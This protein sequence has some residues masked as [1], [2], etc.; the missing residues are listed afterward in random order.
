M[1]HCKAARRVVLMILGGLSGWS[2]CAQ[3]GSPPDLTGVSLE[4]L[5]DL[6]VTSVSKKEQSLSKTAGAVLV[7]TREDIKHSGATNLPD[8]LR[9]VPGVEVARING[10]VWAISIRGFN[11]RYSGTVLV[12][13]D[14]RSVYNPLF[15]GVYWDQESMPLENIERI[16]VIR[17]PSGTVWGANAMNGAINIIT[18]SSASTQGALVSVEAGSH[19]L[20]QE[21]V[22][23]GGSAGADG[24]Y[25]VYGRY[26][27]TANSPQNTGSSAIDRGHNIQMGFRSD[28]TLSPRDTLTV[29]GDALG[30]AES[31]TVSTVSVSA[32]PSQRTFD[33]QVRAATSNLTA[34]WNHTFSDGSEFKGQVYFD[35]VRRFDQ[36]LHIVNTG[37]ADFQYHFREGER[38]DIVAGFGYRL[39]DQKFSDGYGIT[40]G[41]GARRD[42]LFNT[43][44]QDEIEVTRN[45]SLTA[46]VKLEHNAYTGFEYEPSTQFVWSPGRRHTVWG[47]FSK[48]IQQPTWLNTQMQIDYS[49][50][51]IP[52]VGTAVVHISGNPLFR[53]PTVF[54]YSAG[55]RA[56]ISRRFTFDTTLFR[57]YY[58]RLLTVEPGTPYFD[59]SPAFPHLVLPQIYENLGRATTYGVET[60][61]HWNAT[62][63]WRISPGFSVLHMDAQ[64]GPGSAD[65]GFQSAVSDSSP[66]R[67]IQF[68]SNMKLPHNLEWDASAF[69][70]GPVASGLLPAYVRMD[71]TVGWQLTESV[72]LSLTGQNLLSPHHIE[73]VDGY[74]IGSTQLPRAVVARITWRPW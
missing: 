7:I 46:G 70:V 6:Q 15:A 5:M 72:E 66:R 37:D 68:R 55:Y 34:K 22:Q 62:R 26:A 48:A 11:N 42:S 63:W 69:Y 51:Q 52:G 29:Q 45:V 61:A 65:S 18:K 57:S 12:L 35:R 44:L 60:A 30:A 67:Q 32:L 9:M 25:R 43:F 31:Q 27:L 40:V 64:T 28:W 8:L 14:G 58:M 39:T 38:N 4:Q 17:G 2:A 10:N 71:T 36:G 3:T 54:N 41:T 1:T 50:V 73:S 33:D 49:E 47:S 19:D 20:T 16:E 56:E 13:V 74:T 21:L 53:A 24:T 23:Y 59:P